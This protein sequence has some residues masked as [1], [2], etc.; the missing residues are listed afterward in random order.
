VCTKALPCIDVVVTI[1]DELSF[2]DIAGKQEGEVPAL[3]LL[4]RSRS[5]V[6][7][8]IDEMR[9]I[10]LDSISLAH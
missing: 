7:E 6:L 5:A 4:K 3:L 2:S 9:D 8:S 1:Q 10:R